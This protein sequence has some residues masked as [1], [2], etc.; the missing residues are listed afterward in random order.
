MESIPDDLKKKYIERR[1]GDLQDCYNYLKSKNFAGLEKVGHRL[2]GNGGTFG[3]PLI[4]KIGDKIEKASAKEDVS[5][6][7]EAL[8]ELASWIKN[9]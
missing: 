8:S 3:Y 7:Q 5:H 2:K 4:T 9:I 1:K 6:V